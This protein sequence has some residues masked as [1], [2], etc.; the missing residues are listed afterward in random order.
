M[1]IRDSASNIAERLESGELIEAGSHNMLVYDNLQTLRHLFTIYAKTFLPKNEVVVF[2]TQYDALDNIERTLWHQGIDVSGYLDDG[3]LFIIDA[4]E[5]YQGVDTH[6]IIKLAL[7]LVSRVKK[8]NRRG[9]T[10][11]GEIGSFFS[12]DKIG[13][14]IDFELSFPAKFDEKI[15]KTVCCYHQKNFQMLYKNEKE[16]LIEHHHRAI[17]TG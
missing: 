16:Q 12:F 9:V 6:G 5:G 14:L 10:V 11:F 4:Q 7:S 17:I 2:G 1:I 15:L 3:T 8:E 13:D